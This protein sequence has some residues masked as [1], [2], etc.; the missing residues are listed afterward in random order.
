MGVTMYPAEFTDITSII[1]ILEYWNNGMM[2][3]QKCF[4]A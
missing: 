3:S 1:G 2:G 4:I